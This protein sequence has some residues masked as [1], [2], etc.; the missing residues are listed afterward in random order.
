MK[1]LLYL[2]ALAIGLLTAA[3]PQHAAQAQTITIGRG[4]VQYNG[5]G[6]GYY[7]GYGRGYRSYGQGYGGWYSPQAQYYSSYGNGPYGY[8]SG[9]MYQYP[10]NGGYSY[11]NGTYYD[12]YG[13]S[14]YSGQTYGPV[15]SPF[16]VGVYSS[17]G[18]TW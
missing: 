5:Y 16:G 8:G 14:G 12:G 11:G 18:N 15:Y 10:S 17:F 4:G 3:A 13:N 6:Q 9:N 1:H 7:G 2:S